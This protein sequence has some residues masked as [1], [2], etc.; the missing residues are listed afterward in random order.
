MLNASHSIDFDT[1]NKTDTKNLPPIDVDVDS[2][3]FSQTFSCAGTPSFSANIKAD[4]I[5]KAHAEIVLG[6]AAVGTLVP[7]KLTEFGLFAEITQAQIDGI[8]DL[9]G[10]VTVWNI[11]S[12]EIPLKQKVYLGFFRGQLIRGNSHYLKWVCQASISPGMFSFKY[13][14]IPT[15]I[16]SSRLFSL[17]TGSCLWARPSRFSLKQPL[18]LTLGLTCKWTYPTPCKMPNSFSLPRT[19]PYPGD[20][21]FLAKSVSVMFLHDRHLFGSFSTPFPILHSPQAFHFTFYHLQC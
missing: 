7:P 8:L 19:V 13:C 6:V 18:L 2:P 14:P 15:F 10:T 9:K 21:S 4:A 16:H 12:L 1:F 11:I 20:P 3:V 17:A 5:V